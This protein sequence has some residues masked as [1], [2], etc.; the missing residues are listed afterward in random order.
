MR[1][2]NEMGYGVGHSYHLELFVFMG[3]ELKLNC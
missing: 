1:H 3:V 2:R